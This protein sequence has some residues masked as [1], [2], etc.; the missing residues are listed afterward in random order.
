MAEAVPEEIVR[1]LNRSVRK[2]NARI[3]FAGEAPLGPELGVRH[4]R[5]GNGLDV[6]LLVDRAAPVLSY[7]TWL[8]VGSRHEEPGKTGLAHLFEHL[9]FK[10]T[11]N[12]GPGEYDRLTEAAGG[13]NN[14]C[15]SHDYTSYFVSLPRHELELAVEL[16]ADRMEHLVLREPQLASEKEVVMNERR[17]TVDDD[18]E[19]AAAEKLMA[20]AFRKHPYG[21]PIIGWMED[22]ES[23][24][25]S[26]CLRFY[27]TYYAPNN[28]IVVVVGDVDEEETLAT[29]QR[30]YGRLRPSKIPE[31]ARVVEPRQRAERRLTLEQPTD[32]EKLLVGWRAPAVAEDD[33]VTL[34][35]LDDVLTGGRSSRLHRR[36]VSEGEMATEVHGG[37]VPLR[38][39][40][41]YELWA[42][43][44]EGRTAAALL[45]VMDEEIGRLVDE[46]VPEEELDKSKNRLELSFLRGLETAGGK[47]DQ[48]GFFA[49]VLGDVSGVFRQLEEFRAVTAEDVRRV[50]D[51]YLTP[52]RRT[53]LTVLP[54]GHAAA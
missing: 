27:R 24:T 36:L 46:P 29:M 45:R 49:T 10:E 28:A 16:E 53:A 1:R 18:V 17:Y 2:P 50:A 19:S 54:K 25:V 52:R 7:Q 9:M 51:R 3:A 12:H 44:R 8:R 35:L 6:H 42:D 22:I 11:E 33:F 5:F 30:H 26:D 34:V 41:L 37:A 14:A 23:F 32:T 15:T 31:P 48:I 47:A 21:W 20:A 13:D 39:P 38:E 40:G 4:Y 43:A